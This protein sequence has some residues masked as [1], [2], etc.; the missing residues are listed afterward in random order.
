M[1]NLPDD[2][3][4]I[5]IGLL[6]RG[7]ESIINIIRDIGIID[8]ENFGDSSAKLDRNLQHFPIHMS[9]CPIK[10]VKFSDGITEHME[11]DRTLGLMEGHK[12]LPLLFQ[13][14]FSLGEY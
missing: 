13:I 12:H 7:N 10:K 1:C 2:L 3:H 9:Y 4:V 11:E 14:M 8:P 5:D 6:K